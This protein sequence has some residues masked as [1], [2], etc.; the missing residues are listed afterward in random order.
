MLSSEE[1]VNRARDDV[2]PKLFNSAR[3]RELFEALL[4]VKGPPGQI[5]DGLSEDAQLVWVRLKENVL[6]P[7]AGDVGKVYD[8]AVQILRARPEYE[9]IT[10]MSDPGEKRKMRDKLRLLY[11]EADRWYSVQRGVRPAKH[12]RGA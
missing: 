8:Q 12:P 10:G 1:W 7:A 3:N 4:Q 11:P 9:K 6:E 5:P 2:T